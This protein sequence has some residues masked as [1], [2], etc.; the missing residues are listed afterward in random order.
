MKGFPRW[1]PTGDEYDFAASCGQEGGHRPGSGK[2]SISS[3]GLQKRHGGKVR[4]AVI[5]CGSGDEQD[6]PSGPF[7]ERRFAE[8]KADEAVG[9]NLD[10]LIFAEGRRKRNAAEMELSAQAI[11]G[12]EQVPDLRRRTSR[13]GPPGLTS[14]HFPCIA[15]D[16]GRDI[17]AENR[18]GA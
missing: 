6:V 2:A 1:F 12:I 16:A 7:M 18:L 11:T 3:A 14:H 8:R 15:V 4:S 5:A 9:L 10:L 13:C 17:Q